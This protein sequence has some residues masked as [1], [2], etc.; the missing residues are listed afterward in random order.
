MQ[1]PQHLIGTAF[2]VAKWKAILPKVIIAFLAVMIVV[3]ILAVK[4]E[5]DDKE[6]RAVDA[7]NRANQAEAKLIEANALVS[8]YRASVATQ[9]DAIEKL[10]ANQK[11]MQVQM[12][13]RDRLFEQR[14]EETTQRITDKIST[15]Q[16]LIDAP[17]APPGLDVPRAR[18]G[19]K[20]TKGYGFAK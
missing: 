18:A 3:A 11:Q 13:T 8:S 4:A 16:R 15:A 10:V 12:Q 7:G 6:A 20:E 2:A 5:W 19:L 1:Q 14:W 9:N 17:A